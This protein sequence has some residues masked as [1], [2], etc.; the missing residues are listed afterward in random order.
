[1]IPKTG[2]VKLK[3]SVTSRIESESDVR[4][5]LQDLKYALLHGAKID[6]QAH[7]FVDQKRDEKYTNHIQ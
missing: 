3:V 1:M 6:F 5:Y 2:G 7:R 4:A